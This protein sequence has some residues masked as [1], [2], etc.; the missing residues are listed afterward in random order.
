[1]ELAEERF[2]DP[3]LEIGA[4]I[5]VKGRDSSVGANLPE[6]WVGLEGYVV[7]IQQGIN[8]RIVVAQGGDLPEPDMFFYESEVEVVPHRRHCGTA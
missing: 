3:Q 8:Q 2:E 4:L 7:E 6:A 5:R 1:M